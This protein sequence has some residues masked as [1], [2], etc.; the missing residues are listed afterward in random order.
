[1]AYS[2]R[3]IYIERIPVASAG[4]YSKKPN[5]LNPDKTLIEVPVNGDEPYYLY[6]S[7]SYA[8]VNSLDDTVYNFPCLL[9]A[10]EVTPWHDGNQYLW[11]LL[12]GHRDIN[13]KY[14]NKKARLLLRYKIFVEDHGVDLLEFGSRRPVNRPTYA[15]YVHLLHKGIS[16]GNL[17]EHTGTVY[18]FYKWLSKQPNIELDMRC[19]DVTRDAYLRFE[20]KQGQNI[21]KKLTVRSQ[22]KKVPGSSPVPEGYVR[23]EG[24][25]LRPLN[26]QE[27]KQLV[28]ALNDGPFSTTEKLIF[29]FSLDT[30]ARKQTILTFRKKH[31]KEFNPR[32]LQKNGTYKLLCGPGTGID[33]KYDKT[34]TL[35]V[36][37]ALAER[38]EIYVNSESYANKVEKFKTKYGDGL[39]SEDEMYVFMS[40][41]GNP[42]YMAKC[43]PRYR[44]LRT[45]PE[46]NYLQHVIKK[47]KKYLPESF[48]KDFTF[49]WC[50][51]TFAYR[52][53]LFL[54]PALDQGILKLGDEI[55]MVQKRMAHNHRETTENYLKLFKMSNERQEAQERYEERLF[56][57]IDININT[58]A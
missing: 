43:D 57:S 46:G 34:F 8:K 25:D 45:P 56:P 5:F 39:L 55:S 6:D 10:D 31:L 50:R 17:N 9:E 13:S 21:T 19:V 33:T 1:M 16:A 28:S 30:G 26:E 3:I 7:S 35:Y 14:L 4:I 36:P 12:F 53:Y 29:Q 18:D 11:S 38:L 54:Q 44:T 49:H 24:D 27:Q 37:E 58:D 40:N 47:L 22:T 15:Y 51:A 23:D 41:Q 20:G 42:F 52:Y 2:K 48:P 32:N